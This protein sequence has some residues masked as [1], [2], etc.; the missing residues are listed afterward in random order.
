MIIGDGVI[1][2]ALK[3]KD[4]DDIIF[5]ASGV[6]DSNEKRESEYIREKS[7][8]MQQD[9]SKH[10]VYFSTLSIFYKDSRYTQHKREMEKTIMAYFDTYTIIRLGNPTWGENK[11]HL[12]PFLKDKIEK[13]EDIDIQDVY[14][15]PLDLEEFLYWIDL[16][17]E[18]S[19]EMNITGRILKVKDIVQEIKDGKI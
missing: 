6:S 19:C 15:Y 9:K 7:L 10:L 4:K 14:R 18:W 17:P 2:K 3:N 11:V 5:F 8:L 12:I 13:G 1:A 16:I